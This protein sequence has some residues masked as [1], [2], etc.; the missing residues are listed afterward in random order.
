MTALSARHVRAAGLALFGE[1]YRIALANLLNV[2]ERLI[3]KIDKAALD[4]APFRVNPAWGPELVAALQGLPNVRRTQAALA[5]QVLTDLADVE[6]APGFRL[7]DEE[8]N[9][10]GL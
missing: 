8:R 9:R 4:G 7:T 3:R 5:S 6:P 1:N 10:A 2:N